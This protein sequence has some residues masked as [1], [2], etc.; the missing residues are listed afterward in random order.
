MDTPMHTLKKHLMVPP[1]LGGKTKLK[2]KIFNKNRLL[3]LKV[4]VV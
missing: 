4:Y 3:I 1:I 2:K